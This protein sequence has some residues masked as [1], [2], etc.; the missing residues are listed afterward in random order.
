MP[1]LLTWHRVIVVKVKRWVGL[2]S[3]NFQTVIK[4]Y[5]LSRILRKLKLTNGEFPA[6][7]SGVLTLYIQSTA[8]HDG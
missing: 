2:V 3:Q 4:L 5:S 1:Q 7:R 6:I 8:V